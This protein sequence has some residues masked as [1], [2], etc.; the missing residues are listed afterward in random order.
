MV[1]VVVAC[2]FVYDQCFMDSYYARVGGVPMSEL[3]ALEL[4]FA[5]DMNWDL[6]PTPTDASMLTAFR[7]A[8][9]SAPEIFEAELDFV[10]DALASK[11]RL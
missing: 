6:C 7:F 2:K 9:T 8:T 4:A 3:V 11:A 10:A 1:S 5:K